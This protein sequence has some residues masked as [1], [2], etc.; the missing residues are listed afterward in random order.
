MQKA[1]EAG[2]DGFLSK[3]IDVDRFPEQI[4]RI[5]AGEAIWEMGNR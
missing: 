4:G 5:L 2:F 1:R 3:P